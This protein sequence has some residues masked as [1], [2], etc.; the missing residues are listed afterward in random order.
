M[1]NLLAGQDRE[2]CYCTVPVGVQPRIL[3]SNAWGS[4]E[5]HRLIRHHDDMQRQALWL[6]T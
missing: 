3:F 5:R 1:P 4:V 6:R 2:Q